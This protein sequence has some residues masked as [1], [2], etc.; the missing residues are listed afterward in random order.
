MI[1][2]MIAATLRTGKACLIGLACNIL[3]TTSAVATAAPEPEGP[4][5]FE[6]PAHDWT[7]EIHGLNYGITVWSSSVWVFCG[8]VQFECKWPSSPL[9]VLAVL[10]TVLIASLLFHARRRHGTK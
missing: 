8:P 6:Y 5:N 2:R 4:E 10:L 3:L 9:L 7:T 1:H